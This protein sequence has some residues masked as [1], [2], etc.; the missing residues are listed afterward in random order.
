MDINCYYQF[1]GHMI[2]VGELICNISYVDDK[3][4]SLVSDFEIFGAKS[5]ITF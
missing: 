2:D 1:Q 3:F 5:S 4:Q